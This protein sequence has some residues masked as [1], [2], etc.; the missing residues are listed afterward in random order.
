MA[1]NEESD[2]LV[3]TLEKFDMRKVVPATMAK[4]ESVTDPVINTGKKVL[5]TLG[6]MEPEPPLPIE[7]R[8]TPTGAITKKSFPKPRA[9]P[10]EDDT[11]NDGG[12]GFTEKL[13]R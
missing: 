12:I 11:E 8:R 4:I 10:K 9:A 6:V 2:D 7:V 5:R 1:N 13:E 3:K